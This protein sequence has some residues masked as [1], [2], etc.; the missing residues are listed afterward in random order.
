MIEIR[1]NQRSSDMSIWNKVLV[2]LIIVALLP[3][4]YLAARTLKTH[5]AWRDAARKYE[6]DI[7]QF[8]K[9]DAEIVNG[10]Q[11]NPGLRQLRVELHR[12]AVDRGRAWHN[13]EAKIAKVDK[14]KGDAEIRI[15]DLPEPNTLADKG[16]IV[17][18]A[19]EESDIRDKG[20]YLG[21]F[22]VTPG[23]K[24][25][26]LQPVHTLTARECSR[27]SSARG[28]WVLYETMPHD[29]HAAFAGLTDE[30]KSTMLPPERAAEY[31]KHGK[32]AAADDPQDRVADGNYVR[33]LRDYKTLFDLDRK[34]LADMI[35]LAESAQTDNALLETALAK[36][37]LQEAALEKQIAESKKKLAKAERERDIV[38]SHRENLEKGA[39]VAVATIKQLME[40]NQAMAGQ[41]AH[42]QW[43][44]S[45]RID[46][47]I[48]AM[49]KSDT[50]GSK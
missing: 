17:V 14:A 30:D 47:R 19:F 21:E 39:A 4:F 48:R 25:V 8:Q 13:C 50:T 37:K 5:K 12:L 11:G 28:P 29:S 22:R 44:A 34:N 6:A 40:T 35:D 18:Y 43:D 2:G 36:A 46:Q 15:A 27:L 7:R 33:R 49:A 23:D 9:K 20:R 45:R 24:Q 1:E 26:I 38:N 42:A 10:S 32:P 31:V 3:F 16:K 41:L